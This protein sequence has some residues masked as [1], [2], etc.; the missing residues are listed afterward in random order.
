MFRHYCVIV[1]ELV[2]STLPSYTR[3]W[4]Q[5]LII[6]F[7]ILHMFYAVEI[8]VFKIFKILKLSYYNKMAKII[9]LLRFS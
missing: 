7:E 5:L 3:M 6:Q 8:S 1:R 2:I 9:I 4:V